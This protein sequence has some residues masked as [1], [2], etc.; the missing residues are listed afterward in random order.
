MFLTGGDVVKVN[1]NM[2]EFENIDFTLSSSKERNF[3]DKIIDAVNSMNEIKFNS[4][5]NKFERTISLN[6]FQV[7]LL[8]KI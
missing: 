7:N 6:N 8:C 2:N 5:C 4:S 3:I 1:V